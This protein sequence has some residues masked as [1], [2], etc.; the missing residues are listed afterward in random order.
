MLYWYFTYTLLSCDHL[1]F[2]IT[3]IIVTCTYCEVTKQFELLRLESD[4]AVP[5]NEEKIIKCN[6]SFVCFLQPEVFSPR[7]TYYQSI[8]V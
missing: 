2:V 4:L 5:E 1:Y 7:Y 6:R 8:F 3:T